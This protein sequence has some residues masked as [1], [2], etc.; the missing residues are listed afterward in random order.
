MEKGTDSTDKVES[1]KPNKAIA[2]S[3]RAATGA[4]YSAPTRTLVVNGAS[5]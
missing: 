4:L 5:A 1:E 2:V 3:Q